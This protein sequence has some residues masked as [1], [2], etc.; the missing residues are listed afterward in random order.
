MAFVYLK[1][2]KNELEQLVKTRMEMLRAVKGLSSEADLGPVEKGCRD[3]YS[4]SFEK[5]IHVAYLVY[6]GEEFAGCGGISF[7]QV[8][9]TYANP[10][11][12]KAYIMNIYTVAKYRGQGMATNVVDLLVK[13]ALIRNIHDITLRA[14]EMGR[15]IYQRYGFV[16]DEEAMMLKPK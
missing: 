10:T 12:R 6:D 3:Y 9:P 2:G 5:D 15:P 16:Q 11:G 4:D 7:Y 1:A 14:T 8:M 13:E